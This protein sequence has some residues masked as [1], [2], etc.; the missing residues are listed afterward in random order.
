MTWPVENSRALAEPDPQ[1]ADAGNTMRNLTC[2]PSQLIG[3]SHYRRPC[4]PAGGR[5]TVGN[6]VAPVGH[7]F[8]VENDGPQSQVAVTKAVSLRG[9]E[10]C[11]AR[12]RLFLRIA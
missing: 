9:N 3:G 6:A 7:G 2:R 1:V 10:Y 11:L 8:R 12:G 4:S 5:L